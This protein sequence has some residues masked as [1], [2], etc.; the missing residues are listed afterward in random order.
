MKKNPHDSL[1]KIMTSKAGLVLFLV[2]TFVTTLVPLRASADSSQLSKYLQLKNPIDGATDVNGFI[3]NILD[4]MVIILS[5]ILVL[6]LLYSGFLFV[7]AQ[8][9]TEKLGEAKK[10][11]I[12][13][14]VGAAI[15]FGA[16][17]VADILGSTANCLVGSA[18]CPQ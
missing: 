15:V 9:N 11:L 2:S 3:S 17:G 10:A 13:T 18:G 7:S 4:A 5:P 6:A 16:H 1:L 12:W 8:G 14:V